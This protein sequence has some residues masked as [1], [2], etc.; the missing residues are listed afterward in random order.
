MRAR[1]SDA[2][3]VNFRSSNN[4]FTIKLRRF[5]E[6]TASHSNHEFNPGSYYTG[7][8]PRDASY[9]LK[10]QFL[11]ADRVDAEQLIGS[12]VTIWSHQIITSSSSGNSQPKLIYGRGSPEMKFK[13]TVAGKKFRQ[14]CDGALPTTIYQK[15]GIL[16]IYAQ[17]PDIDSTALMISTTAWILSASLNKL[18]SDK[19]N[20]LIDRMLK[21]VDYLKG[22]DIDNDGLLEQGHN[23][24]WMDTVLRRGKIVY[25]QASFILALKNLSILLKQAGRRHEAATV[26]RLMKKNIEAVE[27]GLWAHEDGCYI[28]FQQR[29]KH[30]GGPYR[31]LTQDV[32]LYIIAISEDLNNSN[33]NIR[34]PSTAKSS[35][36]YARAI[37][38]LEAIKQRIWKKKWP[39][40]TEVELKKS[41]PWVLKPNRYHNHTF[42][43]WTTGLEML[44]RSRFNQIEDC[45]TLFLKL[46]SEDE[47]HVHTFYEWINPI[48]DKAQGAYPFR[49]GIS[50]V[51]IALFEILA[52]T[53]A[54]KINNE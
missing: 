50:A 42:W 24:D 43:P 44:A 34:R 27:K 35:K 32:C 53:N 23:E 54:A 48:T 4:N 29:E 18:S 11:S 30:I 20:F 46:A 3:L 47:P 21:A 9:I 12:L 37:S 39:L 10:D 28:D 8:W 45:N 19:V 40:V 13:S 2:K 51:R 31:T 33:N 38:T 7:I 22:R 16:E 17:K 52:K 6:K 15:E 1:R 25:S 5:L 41:G 49:T 26:T 14:E 36:Q